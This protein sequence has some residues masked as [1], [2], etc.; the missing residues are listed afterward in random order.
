MANPFDDD[1]PK[2]VGI[3]STNPFADD[4]D[5]D[6]I[7]ST[8]SGGY[9]NTPNKQ[10]SY[11]P[12]SAMNQG[13]MSRS[14]FIN[15]A[16]NNN[17][18]DIDETKSSWQDLGMCALSYVLCYP[19]LFCRL[20]CYI[21][22][23]CYS[24]DLP[25][26]RIRLYSNINNWG[27][28]KSNKQ[29][30]DSSTIAITTSSTTTT[31]QQQFGLS[32]YPKS[33]VDTVRAHQNAHSSSSISNTSE[34]SRLLSTTTT[35][36]LAGCP[37]GGPIA[38]VTI[39]LSTGGGGSSSSSSTTGF[40]TKTTIRIIR[41]SG[42]LL[43]S[44][45]FPPSPQQQTS[46]HNRYTPGD[47]LT[48]G[49]TSRCVLVV[50]LRDSLTLCYNLLGLLVLPPFYALTSDGSAMK[51][52][53]SNSPTRNASGVINNGMD[54]LEATVYEGGVAVLGVDMNSS[55]VELLD[56]FDDPVYADGADISSRRIVP[57]SNN[58]G[59]DSTTASSSS[60]QLNSPPHYA[61]V[62]PLPSGM[63]AR[64]KHYTFQ[65]I[66]VLPR[67]YAP[68]LRPELF[69]STSDGSVVVA[70][71]HP[72]TSMNNGFT[73]VDCR[74]RIGGSSDGNN[75]GPPS[76]IV[77]MAFAPNGRFL[78]CYTSNS[79]LTVVSTN[80]ESKVLEFDAKS[81]SA[82]PPRSM[83]WCGEDSV[84]LHWKNLGVLMVGPYGDWLRFP[85]DHDISSTSSDEVYLIPEIDC[86]RVV[87]SKSV[88]IIQR[89]PPGTA[90]ILRIGSIEP[91]ALLLDASD[92]FDSGSSNSDEAAR[93]ITQHEG[94]LEEAILG[95]VQAAVGEFDIKVQ[96]RMLRAASYGLHFACKDGSNQTGRPSPEAVTFVNTSR[97]LR[98]M[99]SLRK[100]AIG[101]AITSSQYDSVMPRGVVARLVAS[102]KASLG[103]AIADYLKLGRK[104]SDYARAMKAA[105]YVTSSTSLDASLTDSQIAEEAIQIIKGEEEEEKKDVAI[106]V[107]PDQEVSSG[108]YASV[109]L[110]AHRAGRR[111]VADLLIMLEQSPTDKVHA[112]LAIGSYADAAAVACRARDPDLIHTAMNVYEQSLSSN[113]EEGKSLYFSGII[114]KFPM[115]AVNMFTTYYSRFGGLHGGDARPSIN[116]LLRRQK[117]SEA[118]L[119][120]AKKAL[121]LRT[122]STLG[123]NEREKQKVEALKEASNIFDLGG[124]DCTFQ[125]S[126]TDEQVSLIED[127]AQIRRAFGSMEVAPPSSSVTSTIVSILKY[128]A[129]DPRS[130]HRLRTE[131]D[132]IGRKYK[133]PE[134]RLWHLKVRALSESNQWPALRNLCDSRAKPPIGIKPFAQA[135]I[136][137]RQGQV[138]IMHYIGLMTS[139]TD[140]EDRYDL[141]CEALMWSKAYDE[142][143]RLGDPRKIAHVKSMTDK[144]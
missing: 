24:G 9:K 18:N 26:R 38:T 98:V 125:K 80:F 48:I 122:T 83:G 41:N 108:M 104:V 109:A 102:G 81:G 110:A 101:F 55:V 144:Y 126:C 94:L 61:I 65:C 60:F 72:S 15:S 13:S 22:L 71:L 46:I 131:A 19:T 128:A 82:S 66:A 69:L 12:S 90:D 17:N 45:Q 5:D 143:V 121:S 129:V 32:Y 140:A 35:T 62:T 51:G 123:D 76:P 70:E 99:N 33:Y 124:K 10:Q 25:Y 58:S 119:A 34:L 120:M 54:L 36:L 52:G 37:N 107:M 47:I 133:I 88:E 53:G 93:S 28:Q 115:E 16:D 130:A 106:K 112:L 79:V 68:S 78:A 87:T 50:V 96:K 127:Q 84:V 56:E 75:F 14:S 73:D 8:S 63:F 113:N 136:K 114:N 2:H 43:S 135:V 138:E 3:R 118:G 27:Y 111:G 137:G 23:S 100:P 11:A 95:C 59:G 39:P 116:I 30:Q 134:K 44:I 67:Q 92:A 132:R 6:N 142:A 49:F 85:Y 40:G 74:S 97:K 31:E 1:T 64:S 89:V 7:P 29:Q 141:Y 91:G 139:D 57:V 4:N 21:Y 20:S 86:C 77:S 117:H 105:S 42:V 103:A